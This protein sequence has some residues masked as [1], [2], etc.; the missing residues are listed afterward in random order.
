M[1][2]SGEGRSAGDPSVLLGACGWIIIT[3]KQKTNKKKAFKLT[4]QANLLR[5]QKRF[6]LIVHGGSFLMPPFAKPVVM[7][8]F[9][10]QSRLVFSIK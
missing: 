5:T 10:R 4:A 8:T 2:A 1:G 9:K 6:Y 3:W 7:N